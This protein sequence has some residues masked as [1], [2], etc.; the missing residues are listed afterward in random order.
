[1]CEGSFGISRDSCWKLMSF[2]ISWSCCRVEDLLS[3]DFTLHALKVLLEMWDSG[4]LR[5]QFVNLT[6][7]NFL[8]F[9]N[10]VRPH[11]FSALMLFVEETA[12]VMIFEAL[13]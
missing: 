4:R 10:G 13:Y 11:S 7:D 2:L 6:V 8:L 1:M 12:P 5:M 3:L 9:S